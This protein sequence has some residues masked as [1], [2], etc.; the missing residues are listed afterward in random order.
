MEH[1]TDMESVYPPHIIQPVPSISGGNVSKY[2]LPSHINVKNGDKIKIRP[3]TGSDMLF[4]LYVDRS[5]S[6]ESIRCGTSS[7]MASMG[8]YI[9][10]GEECEYTVTGGGKRTFVC[11][12]YLVKHKMIAVGNGTTVGIEGEL[13]NLENYESDDN[14][15]NYESD[16]VD[17]PPSALY[18]LS[19]PP[20]I[21]IAE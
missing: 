6:S 19:L 20:K 2:E 1:H 7:P 13:D 21:H 11:F 9:K 18:W 4:T 10:V 15:G 3:P 16:K 12:A 5:G 14:L 17:L 8:T